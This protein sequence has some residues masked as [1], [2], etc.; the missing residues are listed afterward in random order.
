MIWKE[1]Q[2]APKDGTPLL[3]VVCGRVRVIQWGKTSHVPL[4]GWNLADQGPENFDLCKPE[5]W[6]HFPD[7]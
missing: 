6:T 2:D 5:K 4:Y 7:A 3:A 1:M